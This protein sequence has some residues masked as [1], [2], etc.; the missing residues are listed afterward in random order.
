M[1]LL[2][3]IPHKKARLEIIPLIDI[4]F[5]LLATMMLVSLNMVQL[6]TLR[7]N[8]PTAQKATQENKSDFSTLAVK[9]DGTIW[10]DRQEIAKGDLVSALKKLKESKPEVRVL[11]SGDAASAHGDVIA[12][13]D[14][15]RAAGIEKVAFQTKADGASAPASN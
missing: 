2:S 4:M 1:K 3:P 12:V 8:L 14:R 13:L 15:V 6:K 11:I 9:Q 7:L 5:F 10:L